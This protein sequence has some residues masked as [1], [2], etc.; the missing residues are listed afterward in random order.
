MKM[1][2]TPMYQ[3]N[4]LISIEYLSI[5]SLL[6]FLIFMRDFIFFRNKLMKSE[7]RQ[8]IVVKTFLISVRIFYVL[9]SLEK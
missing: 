3:N 7:T 4:E 1:N 8:S 5:I 2:G 6:K 9:F